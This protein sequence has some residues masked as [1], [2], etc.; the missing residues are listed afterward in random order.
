MV[1]PTALEEPLSPA[2]SA[3]LPPFSY[4]ARFYVVI[5]QYSRMVRRSKRRILCFMFL[6]ARPV[7]YPE[8]ALFICSI[9]E[10]VH[11]SNFTQ[12]NGAGV[13]ALAIE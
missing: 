4:C 5:D 9:V 13:E 12:E 6:T 1:L 10:C 3:A 8:N 11:V 7:G 2:P